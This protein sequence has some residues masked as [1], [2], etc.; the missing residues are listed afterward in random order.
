MVS[1]MIGKP[2]SVGVKWGG[3]D[4]GVRRDHGGGVVDRLGSGGN[5]GNGNEKC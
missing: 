1:A 5:V 2:G 4:P 3:V